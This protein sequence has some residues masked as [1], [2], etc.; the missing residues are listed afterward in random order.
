MDRSRVCQSAGRLVIEVMR[1]HQF[2][3]LLEK[4]Q[5][6]IQPFWGCKPQN[7]PDLAQASQTQMIITH[8]AHSTTMNP[9]L[10]QGCPVVDRLMRSLPI[11]AP[12]SARTGVIGR[13][14]RRRVCAVWPA[15][16]GRACSAHTHRDAGLPGLGA[17][18]GTRHEGQERLSELPW[19]HPAADPCRPGPAKKGA[20]G[21][22]PVR[23]QAAGERPQG[24]AA[25]APDPTT[26]LIATV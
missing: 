17:V 22:R 26:W 6:T 2:E 14:Q 20:V 16:V 25:S 21:H 1:M 7:T 24:R 12:P 11:G 9:P 4:R 10:M 19:A 3:V 5:T 15:F 18:A 8:A 13:F 23:Q